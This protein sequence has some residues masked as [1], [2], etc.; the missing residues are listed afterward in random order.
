M[1]V[2][3]VDDS[4]VYRSQI[5]A[6]IADANFV[7]LVDTATN[8]KVALDRI[9]QQEYDLVLLDLEM[10][11][12]DGLETLRR[13]RQR[14]I[15][16]RVVMF[17]SQTVRGS[18]KTLECLSQGADDFVPKPANENLNIS[19]AAGAIKDVLLPKLRQFIVGSHAQPKPQVNER[20]VN[21]RPIVESVNQTSLS[22]VPYAS[23]HRPVKSYV[24][25]EMSVFN[26]SV[27]VIGSS[28]GGPAALEIVMRK[29]GPLKIP[30]LIT[31]HMPP[32]FTASLAK[33]IESVSG[34]EC[35]EA[36]SLEELKPRIYVA[37]GDYH[38]SLVN[39]GGAIKVR[40]DQ[41]E[42]RNSVRPAVDFLFESAAEIFGPKTAGIVLT[43]MGE[44]GC[45]GAMAIK[46][47][48][49]GMIIQSQESCVVFGMPGAVYSVKAYDQMMELEEINDWI[50]RKCSKG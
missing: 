14:G 4:V 35:A 32:I 50:R 40:L 19:N 2:L 16:I 22:K 39:Q 21:A 12:L 24:R 25:K 20:I 46:G 27:L 10:P 43:G 37:P 41:R 9:Q 7:D 42:Q 49:G 28:T 15:N 33:R 38:M 13:I 34:V 48:E 18:E 5:K 1:R 26:P 44:D 8:G 11:E 45:D 29:L 30:I 6:A 17:S 31:Q 36:R 47:A 3:V 23:G